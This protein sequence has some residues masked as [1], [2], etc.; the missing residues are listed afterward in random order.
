M[1][2]LQANGCRGDGE[3]L[4]RTSARHTPRRADG[5]ETSFIA[6]GQVRIESMTTIPGLDMPEDSGGRA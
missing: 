6:L 2:S 1:H 5:V 3:C 4:A